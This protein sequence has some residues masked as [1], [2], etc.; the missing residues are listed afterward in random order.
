MKH[1]LCILVFASVALAQTGGIAPF[2]WTLPTNAAG[3]SPTTGSGNTFSTTC[4]QPGSVDIMVTDSDSNTADVS[5]D[6]VTQPLTITPALLSTR[7]LTSTTFTASGGTDPYTW[8]APGA[9]TVSGT[10]TTFTTSWATAGG[11]AVNVTDAASSAAGATVNVSAA[12]ISAIAGK[13]RVSGRAQI[14]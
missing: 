6:V 9:T 13:A 12:V 5:L 7:L 11:Y 4:T 10:G 14:Q 8:S 1:L 3:C 2:T